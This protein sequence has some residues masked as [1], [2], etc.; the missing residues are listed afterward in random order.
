MDT[1]SIEKA[2]QRYANVYDVTF[3]RI[4]HRGRVVATELLDVQPGDSVLEVGVGTGLTLPF[5]PDNCEITGIDLSEHMLEKAHRNIK[6]HGMENVEIMKMDAMNLEFEDDTFDRTIAA[7]VISVVPDPARV[8]KEMLRVTKKGGKIVF[9]NHFRCENKMIALMEKL[10]SPISRHVGFKTDLE[11][12]PILAEVPEFKVEK[13][14]GVN[15]CNYW[16]VVEGINN[17]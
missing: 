10:I 17:K 16:S 3:G 9:I 5:F 6:N 11:L 4:F 1:Q 13:V 12:E 8:L 7:Y 2:Y 15:L 14:E